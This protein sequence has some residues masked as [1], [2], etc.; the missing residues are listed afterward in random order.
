MYYSI[1]VLGKALL[2][3]GDGMKD[4]FGSAIAILLID[5][6]ITVIIHPM[7]IWIYRY[8]IRKAPV[9]PKTAKR[10]VIIDTIIVVAIMLFI[11]YF[12]DGGQL[13]FAAVFLWSKVSYSSLTKGYTED[14]DASSQEIVTARDRHGLIWQVLI[15]V[16]FILLPL[17]MLMPSFICG[18]RFAS[19][20]KFSVTYSYIEAASGF[21]L[22]LGAAAVLTGIIAVWLRIP[23]LSLSCTIICA[24]LEGYA[25][26]NLF[27]ETSARTCKPTSGWYI[28]TLLTFIL[29][30]CCIA[31]IK[32]RRKHD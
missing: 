3:M 5:L 7:P 10:I 1:I 31:T 13:S 29:L 23:T 11:T 19:A 16:L 12:E 8:I 4:L 25:T 26:L 22:F 30:V 9:V 6:L 15:T 24:M 2:L 32:W 14:A 27:S 17:S 21:T 18:E 20:A 28:A